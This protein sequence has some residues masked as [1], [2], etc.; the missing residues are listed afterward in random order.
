MVRRSIFT[1]LQLNIVVIIIQLLSQFMIAMWSK[2]SSILIIVDK[3]SALKRKDLKN[4]RKFKEV[5]IDFQRFY[6]L[7][8]FNLKELD[9]YLWLLGKEIFPKSEN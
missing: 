2:F 6:K 7:E 1:L 9:L 8:R 3:F 5:L 4:Y